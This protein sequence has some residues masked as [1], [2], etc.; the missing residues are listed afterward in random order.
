MCQ[1]FIRKIHE[2]HHKI[3]KIAVKE[4]KNNGKVNGVILNNKYSD[5]KKKQLILTLESYCD[6]GHL[7]K[8]TRIIYYAT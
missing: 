3:N 8:V 1:C 2:F 7:L 5:V 6:F 4:E